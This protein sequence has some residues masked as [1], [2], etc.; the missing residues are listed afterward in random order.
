MPIQLNRDVADDVEGED[1]EK[2]VEDVEDD[3]K[4]DEVFIIISRHLLQII[5]YSIK[6]TVKTSHDI[7]NRH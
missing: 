1:V 6:M 2:D 4:D 5:Q 7:V 3:E